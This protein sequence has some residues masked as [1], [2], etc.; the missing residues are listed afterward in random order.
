MAA[1]LWDVQHEHLSEAEF[2]VE[3]WAAA[4][5]SPRWTPAELEEGPEERL[6]AHIAGLGIGGELVRERVL[7]PVLDQDLND[8]RFRTAAA[9]LAIL[10]GDSSDGYE[11]VMARLSAAK[12]E[13]WWGLTRALQLAERSDLRARMLAELSGLERK[14]LGGRLEALEA[15]GVDVGPELEHWLGHGHPA[16]RRVAAALARYSA[17]PGIHG[18]ALEL[19]RGGDPWLRSAALESALIRG[20]AGAW[21]LACHVARGS[22]TPPLLRRAA[23]SWVAMLGDARA[24]AQLLAELATRP[25]PDLLW[26]AGLT[27]RVDAVIVAVE[28]VADPDLAR[29]AGEVISN[30]AGL[31]VGEDDYWLDAGGTR[32]VG[33][34]EDEAL[35]EL[36]DDDLEADLVPPEELA[37]RLPDPEAVRAWWVEHQLELLPGLRYLAGRPFDLAHLERTLIEGSM[38]RRQPLLLELAMRS[39]GALMVAGEA[40]ARVQLDA[41]EDI[42]AGR[43][44]SPDALAQLEFQSG[45]PLS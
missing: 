23:L 37:L 4:L 25:D 31:P 1:I 44:L 15:M 41:V 8:D 16:I 14:P 24:H 21:Q 30:V 32:A 11:R 5:S 40:P 9:A 34:D 18:A 2:T 20:V 33:A 43:V 39:R 17:L 26:A 6:R 42:F 29:L 36:A 22:D 45:L 12:A 28:L 35:P 19:A 10:D 27:G 38:R 3:R 7:W 13:G